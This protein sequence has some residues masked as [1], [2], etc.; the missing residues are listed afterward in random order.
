MPCEHEDGIYKLPA[1]L[2]SFYLSERI[3]FLPHVHAHNFQLS[4]QLRF[5]LY[6]GLSIR[7]ACS[8]QCWK[9]WYLS[10]TRLGSQQ[11]DNQW[12]SPLRNMDTV[13]QAHMEEWGAE[14]CPQKKTLRAALEDGSGKLY[15]Y[16]GTTCGWAATIPIWKSYRASQ[17]DWC[18][19]RI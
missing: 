3:P 17:L 6:W 18:Y 4:P 1:S 16:Q 15:I 12:Q 2:W 19:L 9:T 7:N 13:L 5:F 11:Q 10:E 8:T 14:T